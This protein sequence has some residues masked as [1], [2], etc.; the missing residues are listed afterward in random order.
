MS[1]A[2]SQVQHINLSGTDTGDLL[3][4]SDQ[5]DQIDQDTPHEQMSDDTPERKADDLL[6][7]TD[8]SNNESTANSNISETNSEE[9]NDKFQVK[10]PV[11]IGYLAAVSDDRNIRESTTVGDEIVQL[12]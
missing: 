1:D 12:R 9:D 11:S 6:L 2:N 4:G 5:D 8:M 7:M 10:Q 3:L